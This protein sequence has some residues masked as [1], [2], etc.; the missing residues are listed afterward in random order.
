M[1]NKKLEREESK[2]Y[3]SDL[4]R[5]GSSVDAN[6]E[7]PE[8]EVLGIYITVAFEGSVSQIFPIS[9]SDLWRC[10]ACEVLG[11]LLGRLFLKFTGPSRPICDLGFRVGP[12]PYTSI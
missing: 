12:S 10:L 11:S 1:R 8:R 7:Y 5:D 4:L 2:S 6:K 3:G 9:K